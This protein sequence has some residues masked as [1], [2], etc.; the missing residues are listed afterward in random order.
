MDELSTTNR[1]QIENP[2]YLTLFL[3]V[4]IRKIAICLLILGR[5]RHL[6]WVERFIEYI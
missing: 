3:H 5:T 6:A 4:I 2:F 1:T